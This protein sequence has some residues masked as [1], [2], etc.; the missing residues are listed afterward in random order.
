[1]E[2][3]KV[4]RTPFLSNV[5]LVFSLSIRVIVG[6]VSIPRCPTKCTKGYR[7]HIDTQHG[8]TPDARAFLF[9]DPNL[10]QRGANCNEKQYLLT[11]RCCTV[12]PVGCE[13]RQASNSPGAMD[14]GQNPSSSEHA[15]HNLCDVVRPYTVAL[16]IPRSA[17]R[18]Q[19]ARITRVLH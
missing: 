4:Y 3:F 17:S 9:F 14:F 19:D 11:Y 15:W 13:A 16:S 8:C 2:T 1:V 10:S 12:L 5:V 7:V 6:R 18:T